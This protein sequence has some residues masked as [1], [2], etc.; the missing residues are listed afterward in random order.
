MHRES[1][2]LE[3]KRR[4]LDS[5]K[6]NDGNVSK[7]VKQNKP[8]KDAMRKKW[9]DWLADG[10]R[11]YTRAG[12]RKS[13]SYEQVAEW[14]VECWRSLDAEII[15]NSFRQCGIVRSSAESD[16]MLHSRLAA[17]LGGEDVSE[18]FSESDTSTCT[19]S[20]E[21]TLLETDEDD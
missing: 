18:E 4:L 1:Y 2:S 7:T 11:E 14:V 21:E 8:F 13:A 9:K 6:V 16:V 17:M 3:F 20:D 12:N 19:D 10:T 15:A 5:L